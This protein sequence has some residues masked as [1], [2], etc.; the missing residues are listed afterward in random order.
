MQQVATLRLTAENVL[1]K[2]LP[3]EAFADDGY[4]G[5]VK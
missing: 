2:R 1:E 3:G 5:P 4:L